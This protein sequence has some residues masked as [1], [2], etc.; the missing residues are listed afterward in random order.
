MEDQTEQPES[1]GHWMRVIASMAIPQRRDWA[2]VGCDVL[3]AALSIGAALYITTARLLILV[4]LPVSAPTLALVA[5]RAN[6]RAAAARN[7]ARQEVLK[8]MTS[9]QQKEPTHD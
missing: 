6:V 4:T 5:R 8:S 1:Y 9:L 3:D 2:G 7:Q